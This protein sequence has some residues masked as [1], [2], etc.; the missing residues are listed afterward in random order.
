MNRSILPDDLHSRA[1]A[2]P[3]GV[4]LEAVP[5]EIETAPGEGDFVEPR[6]GEFEVTAEPVAAGGYQ[7]PQP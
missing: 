3:E 1:A 2:A 4:S 6:D 5:E 7:P